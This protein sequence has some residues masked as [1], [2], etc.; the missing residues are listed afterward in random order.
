[1]TRCFT[2]VGR[3]SYSIKAPAAIQRFVLQAAKTKALFR[4]EQIPHNLPGFLH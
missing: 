2:P 4:V 1:M 3:K